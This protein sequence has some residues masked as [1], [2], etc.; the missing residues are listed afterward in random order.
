MKLSAEERRAVAEF[1]DD[2]AAQE[3]LREFMREQGAEYGRLASERLW[4]FPKLLLS[5]SGRFAVAD[6]VVANLRDQA[7]RN[8][9]YGHDE[10]GV[11]IFIAAAR[12][13][14]AWLGV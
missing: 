5:N 14:L 9:S 3:E 6:L 7:D 8:R 12:A 2:P 1:K 13:E 11:E 10:R 4:A